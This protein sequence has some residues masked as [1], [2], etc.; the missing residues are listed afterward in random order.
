MT[1]TC[2]KC[3]IYQGHC[4]PEQETAAAGPG[5]SFSA[6]ELE[7]DVVLVGTPRSAM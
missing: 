4:A 6:I 3:M 7:E 1:V 2:M 5:E